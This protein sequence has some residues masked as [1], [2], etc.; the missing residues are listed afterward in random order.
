[1]KENVR[2]FDIPVD[3]IIHLAVDQSRADIDSEVYGLL[4]R[5]STFLHDLFQA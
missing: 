4:F 1:M 2:R 5:K 3:H